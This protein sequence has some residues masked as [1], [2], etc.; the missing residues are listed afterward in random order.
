MFR[1]KQFTVAQ[2]RCAMKVN[3]DSL[4][5]GSWVNVGSAARILDVGTGTGILALM[6]AQKALPSSKIDAIEIDDN[7]AMQAASNFDNAKWSR[8]LSVHHCDICQFEP[9]CLY[10]LV[11]SNP[12]YFDE[13]LKNTN[14]YKT[15]GKARNVARQTSVLRP[16]TL[17]SVSNAVLNEGASMYCLYPS[18]LDADI[19]QVAETYGLQLQRILYIKHSKTKPPYLCAFHFIKSSLASSLHGYKNTQEQNTIVSKNILTIRNEKG[20]YTDEY[21][22]LCE[23]FYLKF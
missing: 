7:A 18:T 13:A 19:V 2:D 11:V 21:K 15:Q 9:P 10:D 3:T 14:A 23:P 20:D 4:I 16:D 17:F 5:L 8:Q 6:M 1:C 12:P 22:A